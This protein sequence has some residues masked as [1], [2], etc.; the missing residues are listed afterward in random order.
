MDK[1]MYKK[2]SKAGGI[3]IPSQL[4]HA[5]NIPTGAAVEITTSEDDEIIIRKHIPTCMCCGTA[6]NVK[7][8]NEV[9]LCQEC[10]ANFAGGT[11]NGNDN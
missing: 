2:I 6:E 8:I 3:T 5:L 10:A 9:E 1:K 4:R 11:D 7:A